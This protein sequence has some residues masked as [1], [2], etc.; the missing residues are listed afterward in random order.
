M[1]FLFG[2]NLIFKYFLNKFRKGTAELFP[3]LLITRSTSHRFTFVTSQHFT[4]SQTYRYREGKYCVIFPFLPVKCSVCHY[5]PSIFSSLCVCMRFYT[6]K[7]TI[8]RGVSQVHWT[9]SCCHLA[10]LWLT[11]WSNNW[12]WDLIFAEVLEAEVTFRT[13]S[14]LVPG[15]KIKSYFT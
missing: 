8:W 1:L 12:Y 2:I 4:L 5:C 10:L 11:H 9:G 14:I 7:M 13:M 15:E 3:F 6:L